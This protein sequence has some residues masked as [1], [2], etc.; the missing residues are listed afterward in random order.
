[1][2]SSASPRA[3]GIR[4]TPCTSVGTVTPEERER[5]RHDVDDAHLVRDYGRRHAGTV[6]DQ[7][8]MGGRFVDEEAVRGLAVLAQHLPVIGDHDDHR[9]REAAVGAQGVDQPSHLQIHVRDLGVVG[10][11]SGSREPRLHALGRLVRR[12]RVVEMNPGEEAL[13]AV[14]AEPCERAIDHVRPP[15]LDHVHGRRVRKLVEIE[16]VEVA[17]EALRDPPASIEHERADES[18]GAIPVLLQDL[19]ERALIV[20]KVEAAVVADAMPA[21]KRAGHERGMRRQRQRHHRRRLLEAEPGARQRIDP[22]RLGG[23][24]PVAA[25][26]IRANGV[27]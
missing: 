19:G 21:G 12:M 7:G 14:L 22:R 18:A 25:E 4:S 20:A 6:D 24:I 17:I 11:V 16:L 2:R 26:T 8:N 27:K 10:A 23:G 1:M 5:G 15:P 3:S 13:V 9:V